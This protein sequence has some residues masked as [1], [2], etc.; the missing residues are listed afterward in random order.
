[1]REQRADSR[2]GRGV[3]AGGAVAVLAVA[4]HGVAGGGIPGSAG[5]T[6]LIAAAAAIGALA[7]TLRSPG[8]LVALMAL[9]QPVGHVA[10]SGLAHSGHGSPARE[11]VTDGSMAAAHA[12][13]TVVFAALLLLA[14]RLYG[15][16]SRAVRAVLSR[17]HSAPVAAGGRWARTAATVRDARRSGAGAPRAPP[18]TA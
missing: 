2:F 18:I 16:V 17:P 4:A 11:L 1:M 15:F 13:A 12:L 5:L 9:G 7:A 8:A 3:V 6:L 14:E 10:L